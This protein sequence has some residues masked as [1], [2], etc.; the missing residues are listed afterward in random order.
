MV[1]PPDLCV[2]TVSED[3]EEYPSYDLVEL[4]NIRNIRGNLAASHISSEYGNRKLVE[5][6]R[7][8]Y[9]GM[10]YFEAIEQDWF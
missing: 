9:Y 4:S 1:F 3:D 10:E 8:P 7:N 2:V 5:V 6:T